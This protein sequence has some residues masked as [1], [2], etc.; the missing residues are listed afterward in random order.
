MTDY[1]QKYM[2]YK[3]KYNT[4]KIKKK[5]KNLAMYSDVTDN[6]VYIGEFMVTDRV[7]AGESWNLILD[8]SKGLYKA[9]KSN[10]DLI[11]VHE[12]NKNKINKKYLLNKIFNVVGDV[13]VDVGTFGFYDS[14]IAS[15]KNNSIGGP[16]MP[17][18]KMPNDVEY[19]MVTF[20]NRIIGVQKNTSCGD[21]F[22]KCLVNDGIALLL[23]CG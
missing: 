23:G 5:C 6:I 17:F 12:D 8:M 7:I 9:Y 15:N 20:N 14:I 11:I 4:L 10:N 21:G 3:S 2:K 19:R 16:T 22:F 1:E 13:G 18:F